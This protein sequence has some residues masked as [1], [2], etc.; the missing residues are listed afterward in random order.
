VTAVATDTAPAAGSATE[1]RATG[2]PAK[3]DARAGRA[4]GRLFEPGGVTLE[5]V[6][7]GAWEDLVAEGQAE[8]AVCGGRMSMLTGC[9]E[10]G[11][12]LA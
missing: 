9:A 4:P 7:L 8:C 12:E 1:P 11:S 2:D 5:D 10:C 3:P 6:V